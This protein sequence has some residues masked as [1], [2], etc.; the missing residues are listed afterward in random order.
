MEGDS[1]TLKPDLTQIQG[2]NMILWRFGDTGFTIAQVE[3]NEISYDPDERFRGRLKLDHQTGSLTI[4]NIR[5][6]HSGL[7]KAEIIHN[8]GTTY[9]KFRVTVYESPAVIDAFKGEMKSVS[10]TEG[11]SVTLQT[12]TE[13]HGDELIAWRFGDEGKLIAKH[14]LEAKS[15]PLYDPDER[16]RDRLKL[17]NQ[18]GSLTI[19][20][21]RTTD[22]GVY[23]V[24][25]SSSKQTL[26]KRFTVTVSDPGLSPGAVAGIV[27]VVVV[28]LVLSAAAGVFYHRRKVSELQKETKKISKQLEQLPK[29]SEQ[30]EQLKKTYEKEL[31]NIS[32]QELLKISETLKEMSEISEKEMPKIS[33]HLKQLRTEVTNQET[34]RSEETM[35]R[36]GEER[37]ITVQDTAISQ[38]T[39]DV[40]T[41]TEVQSKRIP[42]RKNSSEDAGVHTPDPTVTVVTPLLKKEHDGENKP[43][44][45]TPG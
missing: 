11:D 6:K 1:V 8:T 40:K 2:I 42:I 7:Y 16:F 3:E 43:E 44:D 5:I 19:T 14:D 36:G 26:N 34:T 37:C 13:T 23:T 17:N 38:A 27:V 45:T 32:G 22:S 41:P 33:E 39:G 24:K 20:N 25:I 31:P 35:E 30:L 10:V 4:T 28:L 12:D 29:I 18:T 21:L 15:P 9:R